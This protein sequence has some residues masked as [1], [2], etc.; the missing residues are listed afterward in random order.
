MSFY[1]FTAKI[2]KFVDR[3]TTKLT[4]GVELFYVDFTMAITARTPVGD[5]SLW[6][7]PADKDYVPGT[8]ANSWFTT[9]NAPY[10]GGTRQPDANATESYRDA[11]TKAASLPGNVLYFTNPTPY[12]HKIE[13]EG[14]SWQQA[15]N[16]M[17]RITVVEFEQRLRKSIRRAK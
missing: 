8:L 10:S 12:A 13:F 2:A 11:E 14:H 6:A 9:V 15:P 5:P 16:G 17:V 7:M 3:A 1:P 4:L